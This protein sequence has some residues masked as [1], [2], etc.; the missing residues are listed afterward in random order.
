MGRILIVGFIM[1]LACAYKAHAWLYPE[2]R[3]ITVA[4]VLKL[5]VARRA[6]LDSIWSWARIGHEHR[7]SAS[8]VIPELPAVPKYIDWGAWPAIAGDHSCS[9][10]NMLSSILSTKWI[11]GVAQVSERYKRMLGEARNRSSRVNAVRELDIALQSTDPEYATRAGSNNAHF[12]L[13]R[14]SINVTAAEYLEGCLAQG[15]DINAIAVYVWSHYR[16]MAKAKR[17][18]DPSLSV[19]ERSRLALAALSDEAFGIHFLQDAFAAGHVAGSWGDASLRKGTHDYYNEHG[20]EVANWAGKPLVLMGDSYLRP[21]DVENV[22]VV[23]RMSLEQL[24]DAYANKPVYSEHAF[25]EDSI[26]GLKLTTADT[27]DICSATDIPS[28]VASKSLNQIFM[29]VIMETPGPALRA[30]NG[31]LPRFRSELGGFVGIS[32][33][34]RTVGWNDEFTPEV[35]DAFD[36]GTIGFNVRAGLGL[37]GVTSEGDDGLVF[38]EFG[39]AHV[40]ASKVSFS[41]DSTIVGSDKIVVAVPFRSSV[42]ARIRMPYYAIPGDLIL[43]ALL[44]A[45]FSSSTYGKMLSSA[46]DGGMLGWQGGVATPLGRFQFVLGR[47]LGVNVFGSWGQSQKI[48]IPIETV[49]MGPQTEALDLHSVEIEAPIVEWRLF[50]MFS[51]DQA[52]S[53]VF[54]LYGSADI[55]LYWNTVITPAA[56]FQLQTIYGLG[57]R[58]TFDWRYYY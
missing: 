50:K 13:A 25:Y 43:G 24:L 22:A 27:L 40:N 16:A 19:E 9:S 45:P 46:I 12:L 18:H 20:F 44:I 37:D 15:G 4:A 34:V 14:N 8:V 47:E 53:I 10:S 17:L 21:E 30:G 57:I 26:D 36:I 51:V 39:I 1:L 31:E 2:H 38:L 7:L 49:N 54:Q 23:V 58:T 5:D 48:L 42:T 56:T 11:V 52:S 33:Y 6:R 55:P 29:Q 3:D 41:T 28:T 35:F 32:P